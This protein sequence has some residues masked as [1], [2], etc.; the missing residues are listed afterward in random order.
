MTGKFSRGEYT[1]LTPPEAEKVL[2]I[3]SVTSSPEQQ[4]AA[5]EAGDALPQPEA[6]VGGDVHAVH[7]QCHE[8]GQRHAEHVH[9]AAGNAAVDLAAGLKKQYLGYPII[10]SPKMPASLTADYTGLAMILF[11]DMRRAVKFGSRRE[12]RIKVDGSR[13]LENDQLAVLGTERFDINVHGLGSTTTA[14]ALVALVGGA[15]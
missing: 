1:T 4:A 9:P 8:K 2:T 14:G 10:S 12:L 13:Y 11:G 6:A 5:R 15:A 3:Y 7:R